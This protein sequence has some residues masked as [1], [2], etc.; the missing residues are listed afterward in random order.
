[1]MRNFNFGFQ[2]GQGRSLKEITESSDEL[3][4]G[5]R[6]LRIAY[7]LAKTEKIRLPII[8]TLYKIVFE[9]LAFEVALDYLMR[10]PYSKDVSIHL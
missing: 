9:N 2:L 4:E 5:V 8:E 10:Y 7:L 6:T 1:M 3:A